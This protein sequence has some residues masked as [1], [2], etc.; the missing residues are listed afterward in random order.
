M[1]PDKYSYIDLGERDQSN[2]LAWDE[3]P[4]ADYEPWDGYIDYEAT[5]ANSKERMAKNPH[6][7]LIE[8]NARWLK[9]Q[10]EET[11]VSLNFKKYRAESTKDKERSK[12]FKSLSDYDSRLS[13][14]SLKYEESLFTKDP[15]LREKRDRWH[16][17]L[18]KDVYVEEA[19]NVLEDL[20]MN[21]IKNAKLASVKG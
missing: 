4:P 5:I 6:I 17:A 9:E 11:E 19:I 13:F 21:N 3:I 12:Y 7:K 10:Q 8:E 18:A 14:K 16:K 2:P 20:K 15:V 1:V